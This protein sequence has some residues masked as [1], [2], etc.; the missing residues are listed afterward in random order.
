MCPGCNQSCDVE[1]QSRA[2]FSNREAAYR[3]GGRGTGRAEGQRG[4][5]VVVTRCDPAFQ[6]LPTAQRLL[7]ELL[8]SQSTA[9]NTVCG[10]PGRDAAAPPLF[11]Q[12]GAAWLSVS[13]LWIL[14]LLLVSHTG[15]GHTF[16]QRRDAVFHFKILK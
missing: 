8:S 5:G 12:R 16:P 1:T 2:L 4:G 15:R 10:A 14:F 3:K 9:I 7:D 13:T 11:V 6:I